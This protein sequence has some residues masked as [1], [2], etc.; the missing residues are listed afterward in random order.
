MSAVDLAHLAAQLRAFYAASGDSR[1]ARAAAELSPRPG[2]GRRPVDDAL[3]LERME[4]L[5]ADPELTVWGA[6]WAVAGELGERQ[7]Q[8]RSVAMRLDGKYR[9]ARKM[10]GG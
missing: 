1:F 7:A 2:R 9:Q 8:R 10:V 4:V 5:L 3:A 6:A